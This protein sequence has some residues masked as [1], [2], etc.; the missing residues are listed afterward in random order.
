MHNIIKDDSGKSRFNTLAFTYEQ[1]EENDVIYFAAGLPYTYSKLIAYI[2]VMERVAKSNS[3]LYFRKEGLTSTV[4]S[5]ECPL[6][7]ITWKRDRKRE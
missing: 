4:S 3:S 1:T 6:L 2:D 5:N 7:T